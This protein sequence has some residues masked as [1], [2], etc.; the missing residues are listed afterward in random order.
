MEKQNKDI[1]DILDEGIREA[2]HRLDV[3]EKKKEADKLKISKVTRR[4]RQ[5]A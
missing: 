4:S 2:Y 3:Q 1:L 5:V